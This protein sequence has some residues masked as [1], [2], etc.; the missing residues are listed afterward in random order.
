M[1][2][3]T[4]MRANY[5]RLFREFRRPVGFFSRIGDHILFYGQAI[6]GVPHAI[7]RYRTEIVRLIA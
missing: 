4:V 2:T 3:L 1:G 7:V 5:T 6:G